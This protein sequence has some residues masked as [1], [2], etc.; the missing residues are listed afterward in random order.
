MKRS[1]FF[2]AVL[3]IYSIFLLTLAACAPATPILLSTSTASP[4]PIATVKPITPTPTLEEN[5]FALA[6]QLGGT[7]N[8]VALG[9]DIVYAGIGTRLVTVDIGDPTTPRFLGQSDA[10]F[11][12]V[13][14]IAISDGIAYVAVGGDFHIYDVSNPASPVSVNT[15]SDLAGPDKLSKTDILPAGEL[16]YVKYRFALPGGASLIAVNV[17]E[18]TQPVIVDRLDL[19]VTAAVA[20]SGG[21]LYIANEGKLQLFDAAVP[22]NKLGEGALEFRL[23]NTYWQYYVTVVGDLAYVGVTQQPLQVWDVRDPAKP[24]RVADSQV[25]LPHS[26][27]VIETDGQ[28]LFLVDMSN[29]DCN[30]I[31]RVMD[32]TDST[33]VRYQ[34]ESEQFNCISDIAVNGNIVVAATEGGLQI[35]DHSDPGRLPAVSG[36]VHPTGFDMVYNVALN[37]NLAYVILGHG[38]GTRLGVLDRTQPAAPVMVGEPLGLPVMQGCGIE[39]LYVRGDRLYAVPGCS[40]MVTLDISEPANPRLIEN[41]GQVID[42]W[43]TTPALNGNVIYSPVADG[44]G[45][46]DM[47]DP[48]KPVLFSTL[49]WQEGIAHISI[50]D[51][52]LFVRPYSGT[53]WLIYDISDPLRPVGVGSLVDQGVFAVLVNM[54][55][56][57]PGLDFVST[58]ASTLIVQD[59]SDLSQPAEIGRLDL[60]LHPYE[61]VLVED[62]LYLSMGGGEWAENI[63]AVNLSDLS[64]PQLKWNLPLPVNEFGVDGDLVYLAAGEAGLLVLQ[65]EK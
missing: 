61:M 26:D 31:V 65:D 3:P 35:F 54:L 13:D 17:S 16:V 28:A 1:H 55:F 2:R 24:A 19:A 43:E 45:V 60:P 33:V 20:V 47:S 57:V 38:D 50:S 10:L 4:S 23:S 40:P 18:P 27:T 53:A 14:A 48:A 62:T 46:W 51:R 21:V 7:V 58:D 15:L 29:A 12:V 32:I 6:G 11:N 37:Q 30:F 25:D 44:L 42:H 49:P 5:A 63:S 22:G 9:G 64:H 41:E 59:I 56:L 39:A 8:A 34:A 52:Y 36:F